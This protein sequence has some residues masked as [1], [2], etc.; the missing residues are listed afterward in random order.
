MK[1]MSMMVQGNL[2]LKL[3]EPVRYR[4]TNVSFTVIEGC[5]RIS[6]CTSAL[7]N[8]PYPELAG[9]SRST[10]SRKAVAVFMGSVAAAIVLVAVIFGARTEAYADIARQTPMQSVSVS[11]GDTLWDL[12]E[13]H[14]VDGLS[15]YET[16]KLIESQNNL[17]SSDLSL[18]Q[19]LKVPDSTFLG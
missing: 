13:E 16:V 6:T 5:A 19:T 2:A 18:G 12:A 1:D 4:S 3:E 17:S 10:Y 15:T 14:P 8:V 9:T 7:E 11:A